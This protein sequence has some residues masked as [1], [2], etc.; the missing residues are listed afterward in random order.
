MELCSG[1][2]VGRCVRR[3]GFPDPLKSTIDAG[4]MEVA[5]STVA[6]AQCV[7]VGRCRRRLTLAIA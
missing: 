3:P 4:L 5:T 2:S 7:F 6:G 1:V